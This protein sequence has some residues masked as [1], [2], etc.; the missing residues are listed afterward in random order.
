[1]LTIR[2]TLLRDSFEGGASD[3][4][5]HAEWPP[6]PMRLF[7]AL[8]S[9]ADLLNAATEQVLETLE[10]APPP[11][12]YAPQLVATSYRRAYVPINSVVAGRA[13]GDLPART[14]G[15]PR[16]WARAVLR[17]ATL[18]YRWPT[19]H[20]EPAQRELLSSLCRRVPYFGRSTSPA[21]FDVTDDA[22]DLRGLQQSVPAEELAGRRAGN[23]TLRAPFSGSLA[24]LQAAHTA[25]YLAG[26]PGDAWEIGL[27]VPYSSR[28]AV[29]EIDQPAVAGPYESMVVL[30]L[31]NRRL[32]GRHAARV[33]RYV[34]GAL[35]SRT[36]EHLPL[37]HGH[38][39]GSVIQCAILSLPFV[40]SPHADGHLLGV[41][42]ALPRLTPGEARVLHEAL[43]G[44]GQELRVTC[45]P[46]GEL[47]L[48]RL[49]PLDQVGAW[50]LTPDRWTGPAR[51]WVTALPAVLDRYLKRKNDVEEH[52]RQAVTSS[53]LPEP[54]RVEFSIRPLIPGGVDLR[55]ADTLRRAT[56]AGF[57]PYR[58][59]RLVFSEPLQGPVV[60]GSMRHYGLGLCVPN[61]T[62]PK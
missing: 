31:R 40:G 27:R 9:V 42:V 18:F 6:S 53:G 59:L 46:L 49:T 57:R 20:L 7:S 51:R 29:P 24:A 11:E 22:D 5:R 35:M 32:D 8:V 25:K 26:E 54:D 60:V 47:L 55:P 12:I 17:S 48:A 39:G 61:E 58:H 45:G 52:V 30:E 10:A 4:P 19:L 33:A 62:E 13:A 1:M 21:L 38:H 50:A 56:D 2:C 15:E 3:D 28:V 43:P 41:A 14:N 16:G 36:S 44:P 23:Y 34:K 37:L